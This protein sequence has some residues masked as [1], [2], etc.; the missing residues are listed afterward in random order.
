MTAPLSR[1]GALALIASIFCLGSLPAC[2]RD[3]DGGGSPAVDMSADMA[4]DALVDS[5]V[6]SGADSGADASALDM[7]LPRSPCEDQ[8]ACQGEEVCLA[9]FCAL[10]PSCSK[11]NQ[12]PRCVGAYESLGLS[13]E[14]A[15]TAFCDAA[16]GRCRLGC[17]RDS[18]CAS[19]EVCADDGLCQPFG[20]QLTGVHPGGEALA[21]LR[22]G[23]GNTLM[24]FPIGLSLGG[25]GSRAGNDPGRYS[26]ALVS[27]HGQMH[28]L[29]ARALLLDNGARQIMLIRMPIIF[30]TGP[31]LE[32][33]ARRLQE[34]TGRDWR[35]S[36]VVSGTHTHSGPGRFFAPP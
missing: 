8:R 19:G 29:Y 26:E 4:R 31:M 28:G 23:V 16:A 30:P 10:T 18:E 2:D 14:E 20:G 6:D 27:S 22:A 32:M 36:L 3:D 17:V 35:D 1:S 33:I 13:E 21:P 9:G 11:P 25:Y 12:G 15:D 24:K 5:G 34:R 7:E